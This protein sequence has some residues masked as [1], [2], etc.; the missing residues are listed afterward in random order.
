VSNQRTPES[1]GQLP[2][3]QSHPVSPA[4]ATD[5][6]G[7]LRPPLRRGLVLGAGAAVGGAWALG[8]LSALADTEGFDSSA[9]DVVV[10]T[11]AGSALAA[12]IGHRVAPQVMVQ[13][14][15]GRAAELVPSTA[16]AGVGEPDEVHRVL[17]DIPWPVPIPGNLRLA[18]RTLARPEGRSVWAAAAALAPRGRGDM[19]PVGELIHQFCGDRGWPDRPRIWVTAMDF[20]TGRR[21]VFGAAGEPVA[22]IAEAVMA[23]CSVPGWFPPRRIGNHRYIDGGAVSVTNADLLSTERLDEVVVLAPM[24]MHGPSPRGSA[25]VRLDARLRRYLT[26]R[27]MAEVA[28]LEATGISVRVFAPSWEDLDVMGTNSFDVSRRWRV[29]ETA[30]RTTTSRLV[31]QES[32]EGRPDDSAGVA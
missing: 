19:A 28:Q 32:A 24:A 10:G 3:Q 29:F 1:R 16:A 21:V 13:T 31:G 23:S 4:G 12:L 9:V 2:L 27:L 8:V 26:Q 6:G 14:L 15:T 30:L 22:T 7:R 11:S 5:G 18:A 17:A 20:D 25:G